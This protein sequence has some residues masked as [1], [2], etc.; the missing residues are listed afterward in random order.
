MEE[1][2]CT[3]VSDEGL[4]NHSDPL[5]NFLHKI[6]RQAVRALAVLMVFVIIWGIWDVVYVLYKQLR[7]P[8]F[9]NHILADN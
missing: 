1:K 4:S 9:W 5:I 6:I 2:Y 7:D 3:R 8:P